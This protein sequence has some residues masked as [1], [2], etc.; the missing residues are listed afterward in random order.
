VKQN[1]ALGSGPYRTL[2]KVEDTLIK[3][4]RVLTSILNFLEFC[5]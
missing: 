4:L 2:V 1:I 5:A 3:F